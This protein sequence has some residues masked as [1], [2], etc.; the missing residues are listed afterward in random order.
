MYHNH[1]RIQAG[2]WRRTFLFGLPRAP[3]TAKRLF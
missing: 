1:L 3:E 2:A